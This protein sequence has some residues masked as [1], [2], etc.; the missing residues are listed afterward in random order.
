[1]ARSIPRRGYRRVLLTAGICLVLGFMIGSWSLWGSKLKDAVQAVAPAFGTAYTT[2]YDAVYDASKATPPGTSEYLV[3]LHGSV[4]PET[5]L[6]FFQEH[7]DIEY[8]S[9]S[10]YPNA[11]RIALRIPVQQPLEELR[12]QPFARFVIRNY[13]FLLCH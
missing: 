10:I 12:T 4:D 7:P 2:L 6:G 8:L 1:M 9:E 13:P 11:V 5:Y 3:F